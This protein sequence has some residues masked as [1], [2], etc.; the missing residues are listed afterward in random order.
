MQQQQKLRERTVAGCWSRLSQHLTGPSH[1]WSVQQQDGAGQ[2]ATPRQKR[3]VEKRLLQRAQ[4]Y[5]SEGRLQRRGLQ[6]GVVVQHADHRLLQRYGE[7][8][9]EAWVT[10]LRRQRIAQRRLETPESS[11]R[12]GR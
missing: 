8:E 1:W 12:K 4:R 6:E 5:Q 2:R 3:H 10:S 7:E 11:Q 9:A